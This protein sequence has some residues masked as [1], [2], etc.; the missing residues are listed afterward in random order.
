MKTKLIILLNMV[1]LSVNTFSQTYELMTVFEDRNNGAHLSYWNEIESPNKTGSHIFSLWGSLKYGDSWLIAH[2]VE[3]LK[4]DAVEMLHFLE[5]V[6][7][8]SEKY[9]NKDK[10]VT[11]ISG[12]KIKSMK[13]GPY[14]H[15]MVFD[16]ENK[17][18]CFFSAKQW[19]NIRDKFVAFC[20]ER[21]IDV[22]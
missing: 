21:N 12:V 18:S 2:E 11:T 22:K 3:Y 5:A 19:A 9:K 1:V 8:F 7:E 6:A 17:V 10:V 16:K 13:H 15:T 4:K 20:L 14:K